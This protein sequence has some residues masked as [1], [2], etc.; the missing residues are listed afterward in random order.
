LIDPDGNNENHL[1]AG[2]DNDSE[3]KQTLSGISHC[4]FTT[5]CQKPA[6]VLYSGRVI[7]AGELGEV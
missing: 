7:L 4:S 6:D 5:L 3:N 1:K 2:L